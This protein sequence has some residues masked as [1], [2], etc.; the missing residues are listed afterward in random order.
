MRVMNIEHDSIYQYIQALEE[1]QQQDARVGIPIKDATLVM[2][3]M[4]AML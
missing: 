3:A 4:K 1:A 2:I